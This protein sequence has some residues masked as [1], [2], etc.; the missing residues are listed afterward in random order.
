MKDAVRT[1]VGVS[2]ITG[3]LLGLRGN[4]VI[5]TLLLAMGIFIVVWGQVPRETENFL[6]RLPG[7]GEILKGLR[8]LAP[9]ISARPRETP[10]ELIELSN[11]VDWAVHNLLKRPLPITLAEIDRLEKDFRAWDDNV[12]KKLDN[13]ELFTYLEKSRFD[14][15]CII[16]PVTVYGDPRVDRLFAQLRMKLDRLNAAIRGAERRQFRN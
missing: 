12:S 4:T 11:E 14:T 15:L 7:G 3:V 8:Y 13:R 9:I 6:G 16:E 1:A 5:V 10:S 2:L